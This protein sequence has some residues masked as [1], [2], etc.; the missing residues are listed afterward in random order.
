MADLFDTLAITLR[1]TK[2][3][4]E[5]A[6]YETEQCRSKM[7]ASERLQRVCDGHESAIADLKAKLSQSE[8]Q[9]K[10][11]QKEYQKLATKLLQIQT[12]FGKEH[13]A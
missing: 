1:Q 10:E 3:D 5:R 8:G 12:I 11:L 9:Y 7:L 6:Q 2:T 4:L 13:V